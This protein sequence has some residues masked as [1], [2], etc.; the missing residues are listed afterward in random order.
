MWMPRSVGIAR[1]EYIEVYGFLRAREARGRAA[2]V[3]SGPGSEARLATAMAVAAGQ[4]ADG[5]A[6]E[7]LAVPMGLALDWSPP[8][9]RDAWARPLQPRWRRQRR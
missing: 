7:A 1:R 9:R 5:M 6:G 8:R 4:A 2:A 3:R